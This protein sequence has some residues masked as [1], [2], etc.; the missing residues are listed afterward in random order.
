[1]H[2]WLDCKSLNIEHLFNTVTVEYLLPLLI[3]QLVHFKV[4]YNKRFYN[5]FKDL[6][7][8]YLREK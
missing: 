4:H 6:F 7:T 8:M 3:K 1:M 5:F 2:V